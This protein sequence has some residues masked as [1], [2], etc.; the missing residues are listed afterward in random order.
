VKRWLAGLAL[1]LCIGAGPPPSQKP[2]TK[3][4][5]KPPVWVI[6]DEDTE[7]VLFATVH[8]LP[9]GVDWLS[10]EAAR[11]LDAA[12]MLILEALIPNDR[13]AFVS[14]LMRLGTSPALLPLAE[15]LPVTTM[16]KLRT[17]AASLGLPLAAFE[18]MH[19]WFIAITIGEATL[20][21][22]GISPA[23]G[24]E[25]ALLARGPKARKGLETPEQQLGYFAGLPQADQLAMLDATLEDQTNAAEDVGHLIALWQRGAID[26]IADEYAAEAR[27]TPALHEALLA[28]RNRR[29]AEQLAAR[30]AQPGKV[31]VAVG[32]AHFGGADG[33]LA[34]MAARGWPAT[35]N[36]PRALAF[37]PALP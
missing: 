5:T 14:T 17:V 15:R 13:T 12:D 3:P 23:N 30:M 27:A 19:P 34:E 22:I 6:A 37:S 11:R 24:V 8:A 7:I 21:S 32:A 2:P 29:W 18:T 16:A 33:L 31:F 25:P 20:S 1:L 26:E 35:Q 28:G 10:P 9:G 36:P 4:P